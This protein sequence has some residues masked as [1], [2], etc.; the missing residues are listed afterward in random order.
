MAKRKG[1]GSAMTATET[2]TNGRPPGW[3]ETWKSP[4]GFSSYEASDDSSWKLVGDKPV[5]CFGGIRSL[6]RTVRGR[7]YKGRL[8]KVRIMANSGGYAAV[9]V[10]DDTGTK[11]TMLVHRFILLAHA[12]ECPPGMETRHLVNDPLDCRW[13]PGETAEEAMANGGNIIYGKPKENA[14]DQFRNGSRRR[15]EPKP[16]RFCVCC[17]GLLTTNGNR[18][19]PC[20]VIIG[21]EAAELFWSGV[22]LDKA[23]DR[24]DYPSA[25]GL[26]HLAVRY[27][28]YGRRPWTGRVRHWLSALCRRV[29]QSSSRVDHGTSRAAGS[30]D[31]GDGE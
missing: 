4:P 18:C 1:Q 6:D 3:E 31:S 26:H 24:L 12:G 7:S 19:H 21:K 11:R 28:G 13:A 15:A 14:E 27:G 22:P 9:D 30:G 23:C 16:D 29:T 20:V 2:I 25:A 17:S 8:L 10:T 5:Q